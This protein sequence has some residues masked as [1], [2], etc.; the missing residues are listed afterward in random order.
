MIFL[1]VKSCESGEFLN[2]TSLDCEDCSAGTYSLGGG[3][4][5]DEWD[6][7]PEGFKIQVEKFRSMFASIG[8]QYSGVN[9]TK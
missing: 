8:R 9:C 7:L 3:I 2:L 5:F 6:P 1:I 4:L